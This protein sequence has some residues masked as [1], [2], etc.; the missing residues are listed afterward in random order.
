VERIDIETQVEN[1]CADH[2]LR[3][4]FPT[5][6]KVESAYYD[7][8]FDVIERHLGCTPPNP[9]WPED[10][11]PECPQKAFTDVTDGS[12]G[13]MLGNRGLPEVEVIDTES[14]AEIALTLLNCVGWL[15]RSDFI[16]RRGHAGP[17]LTPTPGAQM[18]GCHVFNYSIIPHKGS[19]HD[20]ANLGYAFNSPMTA[21][22]TTV[23][24]GKLPTSASLIKINPETFII[25]TIKPAEDGKG[26]IV[27]GYSIADSLTDVTI[28]PLMRFK[29]AFR[30]MLDETVTDDLAIGKDGIISFSVKPRE[31]VTLKLKN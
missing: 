9:A 17:P 22:Q 4:H 21:I 10:A 31:I 11:R 20:A 8:H 14:G 15:S 30:T 19:Y 18:I 23:H 1:Q 25:S 13:L 27:R 26:I 12:N 7:G 3:V 5:P 16:N 6:F 24:D 29:K 2:R 28:K